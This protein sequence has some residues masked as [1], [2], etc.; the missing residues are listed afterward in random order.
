M[1]RLQFFHSVRSICVRTLLFALACASV[2]AATGTMQQPLPLGPGI[3]GGVAD[4]NVAT[5]YYYYFWAGPGHVDVSMGFKSMG[6]FGNPLRETMTFDFF[7]EQGTNISHNTV[8]SLDK[9]EHVHTDGDFDIKRKVTIQITTPPGVIRTGGQFEI[10]ATGVV[11]FDSNRSAQAPAGKMAGEETLVNPGGPLVQPG[12]ALVQPAGPL[13][14][15]AGPLVQPAG[16]LV[17][18]G[19]PLV[20][21]VGPL[22]KPVEVRES[23]HEVRVALAGDVLFDFDKA[24]LRP[25][26]TA[27]LR[28]AADVVRKYAQGSVLIEGH[29]DAK[30]SPAYNARLS[31][32]RALAVEAWLVRAGFPPGLFRVEA[33]GATHPVAPNTHRDGSD[34]PEGRQANRRVELVIRR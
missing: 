29:T 12:G 32:E 11:A 4:S 14:K 33:F 25:D 5:H 7:N 21:N 26:A 28:Q 23:V 9:L 18:S 27:A 31:Q 6:V 8:T 3:N 2:H 13:V 17:S 20:Q 10:E 16:P 1:S 24:T 15:P 30:G 22:V 19:G 34:Y